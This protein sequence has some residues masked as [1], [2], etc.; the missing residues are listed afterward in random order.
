MLICRRQQ[1]SVQRR[2]QQL[3][4]AFWTSSALLRISVP[5][6]QALR[7]AMELFSS[8]AKMQFSAAQYA[9]WA[10]ERSG[11]YQLISADQCSAVQHS[12]SV[13]QG[14]P[15]WTSA[16]R[17]LG[18][19]QCSI[20]QLRLPWRAAERSSPRRSA[21]EHA[22]GKPVKLSASGA[23]RPIA[24]SSSQARSRSAAEHAGP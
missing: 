22:S 18:V 5:L 20:A 17:G 14:A 16:S 4:T 13:E 1:S 3:R 7:T 8:T 2:A 24:E 6:S 23:L 15:Q 10:A 12:A 9:S 19:E 21:V 11:A